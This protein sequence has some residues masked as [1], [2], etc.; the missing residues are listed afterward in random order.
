MSFPEQMS[1]LGFVLLACLPGLVPT[2][3]IFA[4]SLPRLAF[5]PHTVAGRREHCTPLPCHPETCG[6]AGQW[7]ISRGIGHVVTINRIVRVVRAQP[8]WS[9]S[10]R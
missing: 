10:A 4:A 6:T 9:D 8:K 2:S 1:W 7:E 5:V 3:G